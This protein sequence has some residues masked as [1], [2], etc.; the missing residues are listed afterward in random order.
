MN[1][2]R[3]QWTALAMATTAACFMGVAPSAEAATAQSSTGQDLMS[4]GSVATAVTGLPDSTFSQQ[5]QQ[6]QQPLTSS[7]GWR[8]FSHQNGRNITIQFKQNVDVEHVQI[9]M[10]QN[11]GSGI[12]FPDDV[13]FEAEQNGQWHSL[14][15]RYSSIPQ[16]EQKTM[17]QT[18]QI[19]LPS[20]VETSAIRIYFPVAVWVFARGLDVSGSTTAQ[21]ESPNSY[22][23]VSSTSS[24]T[25]AMAPTSP[26]AAGIQNMLLVETGA[27]G[28]EG[29]WSTSD[30]EPMVA[31]TDQ[32]GKMTGSM[33]DTML[34]LPYGNVADTET[35]WNNYLND[36]FTA[37]Q[38]LSALDQAV[39][40]A[41]Q[42]LNRPGYKEKVVL[43]IP[44]SPFGSHAFGTVNGQSLNFGGSGTD[45]NAVNARSAAMTWYVN[46]ILSRWKASNFQNLQLVGLYFDE[47]QYRE[48]APGEQDLMTAAEQL[49]HTNQLPLFW[50]PFYGANRSDQWNQLGFDAAWIQP[51]YVEQ[52][53]AANTIRI[54]NA[55]ETAKESGMGIEVELNG[56]DTSNQQLYDTFL[57]KLGVEGFG[58]NQVS[59]AFYDGSKLLVTA[60]NSTDPNQ[61]AV[62]DDT[63]A[64]IQ[65]GTTGETSSSAS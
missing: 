42:A 4:L 62:Y 28:S 18:F 12:Y 47:E 54:S 26:N 40:L 30:F 63:A 57:N 29:T 8:G 3:G 41:N 39:A 60:A 31:Y 61:R 23:S 38:Q 33:F 64:F 25:G 53:N 1:K 65:G 34:F 58:Q 11:T 10:E 51:N 15:T 21:G 52:G 19:T 36:L 24:D 43:S 9:T 16:S 45:P 2:H 13:Q 17:T 27:H 32:T 20:G 55:M 14:A 37:N 5:E 7:T 35:G 59:H 56:L 46:T 48:N 22:P 50:I 6:Y 44:Y 49:A